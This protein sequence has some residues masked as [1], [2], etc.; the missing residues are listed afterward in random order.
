LERGGVVG[1]V[2]EKQKGQGTGGAWR[3]GE[4]KESCPKKPRRSLKQSS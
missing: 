3:V 2:G 4:G 1:V